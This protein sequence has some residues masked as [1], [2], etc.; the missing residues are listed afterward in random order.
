MRVFRTIEIQAPA[1][2]VW[3]VAGR[4]ERIAEFH[5]DVTEASVSSGFRRCT[6]ADGTEV[7]ERIVDHS[8]VHRFYTVELAASGPPRPAYRACLGVR[9]HG[10]HSHVDWDV[11][12][13]A[14]GSAET[15]ELARELDASA[16][17][18]LESLR[19]Q[20]ETLAAA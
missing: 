5:P 18:A 17:V 9:G 4:P 14:E 13:A 12:V 19:R 2:A 1:D 3:R 8:V 7:L 15:C 16:G 11:E 10:D 20:L 6:Y